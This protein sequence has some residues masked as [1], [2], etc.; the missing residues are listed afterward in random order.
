MLLLS[1][2]FGK[3][4]TLNIYLRG[5]KNRIIHVSSFEGHFGIMCQEALHNSARFSFFIKIYDKF[6]V[7]WLEDAYH[8]V[9]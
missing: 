9:I 4:L 3:Y 2:D 5:E 1:L 6:K 8:S 7:G